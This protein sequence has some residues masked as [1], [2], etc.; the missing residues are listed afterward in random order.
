MIICCMCEPSPLPH[1]AYSPGWDTGHGA[2][3]W[4]LQPEMNKVAKYNWVGDIEGKVWGG[5]MGGAHLV[6]EDRLSQKVSSS[7]TQLRAFRAS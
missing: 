2:W 7:G 5:D 6:G 3:G 4:V 1:S